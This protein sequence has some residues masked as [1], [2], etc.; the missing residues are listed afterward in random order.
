MFRL[1]HLRPSNNPHAA[2]LR[3]RV[4]VVGERIFFSK[5]KFSKGEIHKERQLVCNSTTLGFQFGFLNYR[6]FG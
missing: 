4:R 3:R 2:Y 5:A 6:P 1:A